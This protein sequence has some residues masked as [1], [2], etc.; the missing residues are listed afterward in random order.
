MST[1]IDKKLVEQVKDI[2]RDLGY[3][4]TMDPQN[5]QIRVLDWFRGREFHPDL[6]LESRGRSAIVEVNT[7]PVL[8]YDI[9]QLNQMRHR[10]DIGALICVDDSAYG[11]IKESVKEYAEELDVSLCKASEVRNA[12]M[13]LFDN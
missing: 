9:F 13:E 5:S 6:Y 1:V 12:L 7:R 11:R 8:I 3:G 4:T 10:K 2:A